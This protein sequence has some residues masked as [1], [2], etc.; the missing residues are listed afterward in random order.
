MLWMV[1]QHGVEGGLRCR[2]LPLTDREA[3]GPADPHLRL[4]GQRRQPG[5]SGVESGV[6]LGVPAQ[7]LQRGPAPGVQRCVVAT[8]PQRRGK[9]GQSPGWPSQL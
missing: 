4:R 6:G 9:V 5:E 3:V 1:A 8:V 7:R 2:R